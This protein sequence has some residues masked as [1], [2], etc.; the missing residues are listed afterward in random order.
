MN[1]KTHTNGMLGAK[2]RFQ[3]RLAYSHLLGII[4]FCLMVMTGSLGLVSGTLATL[5]EM[6]ADCRVL[7]RGI[8]MG[9]N[10]TKQLTI[11]INCKISLNL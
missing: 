10:E 8:A 2:V 3:M 1:Y 11:K 5:L 4:G 7:H 9:K 6:S